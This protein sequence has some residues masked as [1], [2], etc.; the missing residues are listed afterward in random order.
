MIQKKNKH[1]A[2]KSV[3]IIF[4]PNVNGSFYSKDKKFGW[5]SF[6]FG[7]FKKKLNF[8]REYLIK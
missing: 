1:F 3:K 8:Y 7:F 2:F 6:C 4:S 5:E